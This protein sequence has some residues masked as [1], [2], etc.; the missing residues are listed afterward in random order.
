MQ[1]AD[2]QSESLLFL[3]ES[4]LFSGKRADTPVRPREGANLRFVLL[5]ELYR[6]GS[7]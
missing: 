1:K 5:S 2:F 6:R 4:V 7:A 3:F